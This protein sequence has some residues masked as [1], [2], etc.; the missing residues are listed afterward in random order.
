MDLILRQHV[1]H[2]N[3]LL[4][5]GTYQLMICHLKWTSKYLKQFK[6]AHDAICLWKCPRE[7][8]WK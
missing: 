8:T 5:N 4:M 2:G 7:T 1:M 6:N 3:E